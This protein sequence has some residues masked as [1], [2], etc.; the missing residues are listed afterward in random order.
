MPLS[1][2]I[3][4]DEGVITING[5]DS[6]DGTELETLGEQVLT[7]ARYDPQLPQLVDL[8]GCRFNLRDRA[9]IEVGRYLARRYSERVAGRMAV[10]IDTNLASATT[11]TIYRLPSAEKIRA[12]IG[13]RLRHLVSGGVVLSIHVQLPHADWG[14]FSVLLEAGSRGNSD[15]HHTLNADG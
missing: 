3:D 10:V 9:V 4:R 13:D 2:H 15:P 14:G 5:D 7:D 12:E 11:A 8:R 6:I 1:Y